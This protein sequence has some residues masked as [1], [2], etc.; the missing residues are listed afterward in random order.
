MTQMGTTFSWWPLWDSYL[1]HRTLCG[2]KIEYILSLS[3]EWKRERKRVFYGAQGKRGKERE[4]ERERDVPSFEYLTHPVLQ[5]VPKA[6]ILKLKA[7]PDT[8]AG[9]TLHKSG[10]IPDL[11]PDCC[12]RV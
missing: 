5:L 7:Q 2:K 1:C 10:F 12:W 6:V 8:A 11:I 3:P 9:Q 4:G